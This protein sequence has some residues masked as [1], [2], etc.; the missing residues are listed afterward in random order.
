LEITAQTPSPLIGVQ[1][2]YHLV[3]ADDVTNNQIHLPPLI[4]YPIP[5]KTELLI[6]YPNPFNPETWIPFRL[7]EDAFVT[8]TIYDITGKAIRTLDVGH[9]PA[10]VYETRDKAIYFNGQNDLGEQA[11]SGIYYYTLTAGDFTATRKTLLLK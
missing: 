3:S 11:A 7:A 5:A 6:N 1:P 10:A 2:V 9:K 4:V 8:L